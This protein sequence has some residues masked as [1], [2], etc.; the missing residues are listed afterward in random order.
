[1]SIKAEVLGETSEGV[2]A[3]ANI[4]VRDGEVGLNTFTTPKDLY[5]QRSILFINSEKGRAMNVNA[6]ASGATLLVN[7]GGDTAG[8]TGNNIIG[9][10]A[11]FAYSGVKVITGT[12]SVEIDSPALNDVWEFDAGG[13]TSLTA[14]DA[15]IGNINVDKDWGVGDSISVYGWDGAVVG[16]P[17]LLESYFNQADFDLDQAFT[18]P[19]SDMGLNGTPITG[20]RMQQVGKGGGKTAKFYMDDI[21]LAES[22]SL[23]YNAVPGKGQ[24]VTFQT[25][26]LS[27]ANNITALSYDDFMGLTLTSGFTIQRFEGNNPQVAL[28]YRQ[29]SDMLSLVWSI[30]DTFDDGVSTFLKLKLTLPVPSTL[31]GPRGDKMV[32]TLNDN[33]SGLELMNALLIGQ[34]II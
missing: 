6:S 23:Q 27:L 1:V 4:T 30:S 20:I 26:E 29:L 18:I 2:C 12:F 15:I 14:Y 32:I 22:A 7:N 13:S 8:W 5:R 34:E 9:A 17:V 10:K 28:Q 24:I 21:Y 33:F 19:F 25:I 31:D 16:Q 11:D 3:T